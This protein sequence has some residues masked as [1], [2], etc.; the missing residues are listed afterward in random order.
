MK[1]TRILSLLLALCMVF[2][3][4]S[5]PVLASDS[6]ASVSVQSSEDDDEKE[7]EKEKKEEEKK[8]KEEEEKKKKEEEEQVNL[9]PAYIGHLEAPNIAKALSLDTLFDIADVLEVEVHKLFEEH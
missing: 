8:K 4:F 3:L 9:T 5:V 7:K 2:S 1:K 6:S